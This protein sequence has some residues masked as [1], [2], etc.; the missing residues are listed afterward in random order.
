MPQINL[1]VTKEFEQE[2]KKYMKKR[3]L[4]EKAE[5]IRC[6]AFLKFEKKYRLCCMDRPGEFGASV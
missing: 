5:A 6:A 2:L 1:H 3:R 4:T